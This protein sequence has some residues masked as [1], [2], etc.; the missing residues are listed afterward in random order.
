[1]AAADLPVSRPKNEKRTLGK[2]GSLFVFRA[3]KKRRNVKL[4]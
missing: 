1:M 3:E 4:S 2:S